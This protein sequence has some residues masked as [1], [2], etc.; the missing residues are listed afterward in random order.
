MKIGV[1]VS[2]CIIL[3]LSGYMPRSGIPRSYGN[4]I[5]SF[6]RTLHPVFHSGYTNLHSH[7]QCNRILFSPHPLQHL[8]LV[9]FLITAIVT[10]VKWYLTVVLIS[11]PLKVSAVEHLFISDSV[12]FHWSIC[13]SLCHYNIY[14]Y[15]SLAV[16][17]KIRKCVSSKLALFSEDCFV[18]LVPLAIPYEFEEQIFH[19]RRKKP[20]RL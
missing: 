7:Q 2:F 14:N 9:D 17:F 3:V 13:L 12:L 1:R 5:F 18:Y 20:V 16:S 4:F 10:V 19:F 6:L 11:I 8:L 15:S